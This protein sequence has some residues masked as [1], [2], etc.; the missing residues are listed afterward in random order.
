VRLALV[1]ALLVLALP[2]GA[3]AAS[4]RFAGGTD[5]GLSVTF[6]VASKK[7]R[8]FKAKVECTGGR[9]QTFTY[10]TLPLSR[11]GRFSV[12]QAGPSIDGR[13]KGAHARGTLTLPGCDARA[14]E[15]DFIA[16][17]ER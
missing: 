13:V 5:Q 4:Q 8:H 9:V 15:V 3:A 1:A 7:V 2:A 17:G 12:H 6:E 11:T 14:N 16:N 10:P